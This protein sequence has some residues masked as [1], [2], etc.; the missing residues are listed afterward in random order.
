MSETCPNLHWFG[1]CPRDTPE[2]SLLALELY[3]S[4]KLALVSVISSPAV[5]LGKTLD[6][7]AESASPGKAVVMQEAQRPK[8][9]R[10][11]KHSMSNMTG[12]FPQLCT[13]PQFRL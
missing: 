8:A 12:C 2:D 1:D 11:R 13:S 3:S 7:V 9:E 10:H 5:M 6:S 4:R